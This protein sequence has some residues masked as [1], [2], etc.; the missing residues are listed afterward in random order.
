MRASLRKRGWVEKHFKGCPA[1]VANSSK[2]TEDKP[3]SSDNEDDDGEDEMKF[4]GHKKDSSDKE[5]NDGYESTDSAV[6]NAGYEGED[7][8]YSLL[9]S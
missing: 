6:W 9:V 7:C 8:E 1:V 3:N 5:N 4:T 2:K